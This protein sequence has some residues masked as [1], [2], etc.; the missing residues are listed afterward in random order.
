MS[1]KYGKMELVENIFSEVKLRESLQNIFNT[2]LLGEEN[3]HSKKI[4]CKITNII[5]IVKCA[6]NQKHGTTLVITTPNIARTEVQRLKEQSIKINEIDIKNSSNFKKVVEKITNIDGALYMD[7]DGYVHAIGVILDGYAEPGEGDSSRGARYNSA[8]RYKN[9]TEVKGE[10]VIVVISEDGM[11]DIIPDNDIEKDINELAKKLTSLY[12]EKKFKEALGIAVEL[13]GLNPKRPETF[14]SKARI[15]MQMKG[16]LKESL[17]A[18]NS[19]IKLREEFGQAYDLRSSINLKLR[20]P[21][22]AVYDLE[23]AIKVNPTASRYT[24]LGEILAT[25]GNYEDAIYAFDNAI[26]I[27]KQF[28][29]GHV[30]R[31]KAYEKIEDFE[32]GLDA[33]KDFITIRGENAILCHIQGLFYERLNKKEEAIDSYKKAFEGYKN[34]LKDDSNNSVLVYQSVVFICKKLLENDVTEAE[35]K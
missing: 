22:E 33:V 8:I 32:K 12:D 35:K 28:E 15:L 17:E 23:K 24:N 18:V 11:I 20:K 2:H 7:I 1:V 4:D 10:C 6:Y 13:E 5:D 21:K 30:G 16:K 29:R 26:K 25:L 3:Q 19:A 14:L 9:A 31:I 27:D 34:K